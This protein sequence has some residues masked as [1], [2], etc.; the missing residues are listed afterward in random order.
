MFR[1]QRISIETLISRSQDRFRGL[2]RL[3]FQGR[4][5]RPVQQELL[6]LL[7]P[8]AENIT[9]VIALGAL[10]LMVRWNAGMVL[11]T[12]K[13]APEEWMRVVSAEDGDMFIGAR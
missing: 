6:N 2:F 3:F 11:N 12:A 7:N 8:R 13:E 10:A 5:R 9:L 4:D 1:G